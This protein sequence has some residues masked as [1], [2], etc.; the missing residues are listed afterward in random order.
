[1][2]GA[3]SAVDDGDTDAAGWSRAVGGQSQ[4][5]DATVP[6][7]DRLAGSHRRDLRFHGSSAWSMSAIRSSVSSM[8]AEIRAKP[9][10]DRVAPPGPAVH[11]TVDAAEAGRG[12][13]QVAVLHQGV[14]R[15]G[16]RRAPPPRFRRSASSAGWRPRATGRRAGPGSAPT[17]RRGERAASTPSPARSDTVARTA[18]PRCRCC[19][20][21]STPRTRRG[22][23]PRADARVRS[24]PSDRRD[25]P[26]HNPRAG[27][28]D[29]TAIWW[30]WPPRGR[31]PATAVA[32]QAV[33]A[34][35]CRRRA[36][37]RAPRH[38]IA[39]RCRSTTSRPGFDGVSASTTSASATRHR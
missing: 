34:S 23:G 33:S 39:R 12:D 11:R 16:A 9:V 13:Q 37:R 2:L 10:A 31:R 38:V 17:A 26:P 6:A 22:S 20:A 15:R 3:A 18:G 32:A 4:P 8:P 19:A 24:R 5:R 28:G 21:P 36:S 14:H 29:P 30:R 25:C 27:R 35:C 1:M 7:D